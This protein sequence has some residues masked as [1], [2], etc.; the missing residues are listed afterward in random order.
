MNTLIR[1][2]LFLLFLNSTISMAFAEIPQPDADA[3]DTEEGTEEVTVVDKRY[4]D[5]SIPRSFGSSQIRNWYAPDNNSLIIEVQGKRK[6]KATFSMPCH[7]IRFTDSI[8]FRTTGPFELDRS[9]QV[10]LPDGERCYF[11]DLVVYSD[12]QEE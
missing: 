8:G 3:K 5:T 7:G 10:L 1:N 6:Y 12:G 9:T 2:V 11:K 4:S